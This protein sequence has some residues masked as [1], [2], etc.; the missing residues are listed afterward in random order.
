MNTCCKVDVLLYIMP[1]LISHQH[2]VTKKLLW[3]NSYT[4]KIMNFELVP[5]ALKV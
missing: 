4:K 5:T 1:K 2:F 3:H